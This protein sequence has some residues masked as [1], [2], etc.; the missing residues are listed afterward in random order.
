MNVAINA[1]TS[2]LK[3]EPN[4][5]G[6]VVTDTSALPDDPRE[7][8]ALLKDS[9]DSWTA[10]GYKVVWLEIPLS[11][12]ALVPVAAPRRFRVSPRRRR[13]RA[14]DAALGGGRLH[15][16]IRH[17]LHRR[18]RRSDQ[19]ARRNP[20]RRRALPDGAESR[21]RLQ[22]ARRRAAS[23]R[24]H[25]RRRRPRSARGDGHP[26]Q[27]RVARLLPALA[28]LPLRQVRHLLRLP[29]TPRCPTR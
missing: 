12:S 5:F 7:F 25:S 19:R 3:F 14:Y 16:P 22:A 10:N 26:R 23:G 2:T 4:Q 8:G 13:I 20:G 27:I 9:L 29:P 17:A 11:R 28:R 1:D 6:G 24:T 18:R 15:S 21:P